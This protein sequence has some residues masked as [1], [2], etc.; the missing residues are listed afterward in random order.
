MHLL[1]FVAIPVAG[2][3]TP[4]CTTGTLGH[5]QAAET[6]P[7]SSRVVASVCCPASCAQCGGVDCWSQPSGLACCA[8]HV[9][10]LGARPALYHP[11]RDASYRLHPSPC[12]QMRCENRPASI[13]GVLPSQVNARTGRVFHVATRYTGVSAQRSTRAANAHAAIATRQRQAAI[14]THGYCHRRRR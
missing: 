8:A 2:S 12:C 14:Q 7:S 4:Y 10:A 3:S 6:S 1:L 5:V 13:H 9:F 11:I